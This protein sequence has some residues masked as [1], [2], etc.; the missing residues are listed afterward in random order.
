MTEPTIQDQLDLEKRMVAY[1]V[2]RYRHSVRAAEENGRAADTQYAQKLMQSFLEPIADNISTFINTKGASRTAKY[3]QLISVVDPDKAAYLGLK[4]LFNHFT[5]EEPLASLAIQIGTMLEDEA[6][7]KIFQEQHGDYYD[8]I[9]RDF[10]SKGTKSYR[11]MHRVLTMKANQH[12]VKWNS[13]T[14][15][16]KAA[17]GVKIIDCILESTDLIEKKMVKAK[18]KGHREQATIVPT[19]SCLDWVKRYTAFAE[20]L[21]PDR[22]PCIIPPDPWVSM[23]QGGY[24]TP[25]LRQRTPLVKTKSKKHAAM[26]QGDISRITDAVNTLQNVPWAINTDVFNVL[27]EVWDKNLPVGLPQSEPYLIPDCPVPKDVKKKDMNEEQKE[28]FEEWKAEARIVHTMEKERVSKCFQVIRVLRLGREFSEYQRFW[29]VYQCDFRG[30]LYATVSGLSPQ[31]TDFAKGILRFADGKTL[32][33]RGAFWLGVHGA[34]CYGVDKVS[35][36]DRVQ[37]VKDNER[38]IISVATDPIGTRSFW[39]DADKPWQFLAFCFEW[40]RYVQEGDGMQSYLPIGLDGSCNGLQNFSA[41]LRDEVG[42]RATNLIPNDKPSDIYAEVGRVCTTRLSAMESSVCRD[43]WLNYANS[44]ESKSLPRGLA[45]KPVMTLPYGSTQQSCRESIYKF[46]L[47]EA[48]EHFPKELRFKASVFLT[49]ILWAA[50]GDVVI[51]ARAA[52][53]WIQNAASIIS[54]TGKPVVWWTPMGFPVMQD[55]K[56]VLMKQIHTELAGHF[57]LR[58]NLD[59]DELDIIKQRQGASPNFVHSMDA[60]HLMMTLRKGRESGLTHFACIHDD[61]GTYAADTDIL[62]RCI[63]EAFV[64]LYTE[65]DPLWE[66]KDLNE[67]EAGVRLPDLPKMGKLNLAEILN[68]RYFFG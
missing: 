51:A 67:S 12:G 26:F 35:F 56:K 54:K 61:Y 4:A 55:R 39:G 36:E 18:K 1:G 63:R 52:M 6:K 16:E 60:C 31:G 21:N 44:L 37:W 49:P 66:F 47:E 7:F 27:R 42:G 23:D 3:K 65:N 2:S 25:Q 8:A 28:L 40:Y 64:E 24:Y 62:H 53:D 11:H 46:I 17:V 14:P 41:V 30:R 68:S 58:L 50:I 45:K 10:Q 34:N 48:Q 19:E 43:L 13:W 33:E 29:Y 5:K 9:I 59:G 38:D 32:G 22:V 15:Q 57:R 20:M